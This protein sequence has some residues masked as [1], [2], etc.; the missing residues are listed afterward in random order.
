MTA[1]RLSPDG[2][3]LAAAVQTLGPEPT[4]YVTSIWRIATDPGGRPARLT[5]SAEGEGGP[6]FLPDG[7]VLFV[8]NRPGPA[9]SPGNV[10]APG[11]TDSG[12][13]KPAQD[14]PA[15]W[16]LPA[17][18][19]EARRVAAPP[20][21]V[22]SLAV[23][24]GIEASA[25]AVAQPTTA[26]AGQ[27][28]AAGEAAGPGL[29]AVVFA[30]PVLR[31][32]GGAEADRQR[33]KARKDA[34]VTAILH[35]SNPVR[36]WDHDLGPD[37]LRLQ[38]GAFAP[39]EERAD[40]GRAGD[41]AGSGSGDGWDA[42]E[43]EME[44]RELTPDAGRALDE[45]SFELTPDGTRVVTGWATWDAAGNR[46]GEVHVVD[47][48]TG[49]RRT[50]LAAPDYDF[51]APHVSPDGR[52]VVCRR[53]GHDTYEAPGDITLVLA[54]LDGEGSAPPRD[55]L[56]GLDRRPGEVAWAP[57]SGAVYF[58]ADD[59]GRRPVFRVEVASGQVARLT[60]DH[61]AY[62]NL[63]PAPDGRL[64]YA[65]RSA[66]DEPPTPVRLDV[67]GL[68]DAADRG[69]AR[70]AAP[71]L[72][73]RL[74]GRLEEI[75]TTAEDGAR[76]RAWLVLPEQASGAAPAPLLLWVHGGPVMSWNAWSWRWNP[77]LMA[78]RG[79]A[80]L[81]PDPALSTGYGQ[82]FIARGHGQ[83][84][85][86]PYDDLMAITDAAAARPDIDQE[87]TAM[88][89]GSYGGYMANWMAG[90]TDRFRAIVS[91]AGVWFLDQMFGTT[92]MP[93]YWRRMFGDPATQPER[94]LA[95]S[96]H[97]HVGQI[98]TP[99]LVIHGD[100]DYRVPVS[101]ALRLWWDLQ[102][103]L[104]GAKFLYFPDENHWILG[105]GHVQVWYETVLAFLAEHV[106]GQEWR[107]PEL[108]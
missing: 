71:G 51:E 60:A 24:R 103:R 22:S 47:V 13:G 1:L 35:E 37:S 17:A 74:P 43:A 70:L 32:S 102:G 64:L 33:R 53:A 49:E 54:A 58:T 96:P 56:P 95:S 86:A 27:A 20:G 73:V 104:P 5:R 88:M 69:V 25:T 75:E 72:P 48:A 39:L 84:G 30:S 28:A 85:G 46:I 108:L 82:D 15:L 76:I 66:V 100:K 55:L 4:K 21:G 89:G 65:L 3:W 80:V 9:V 91:H 42:D 61:G 7:S 94:Y 31:G 2:S 6:E 81:L 90:H 93:A 83:W 87:R 44:V 11:D 29:G 12:Q 10:G 68:T 63:C 16:L 78:A 59:H 101:E 26:T 92:D 8:S 99:M 52:T 41:G 79:Y 98:R 19:G 23:A 67:A 106:L 40:A 77:W 18:G 105:P 50:L 57:D 34:G 97:V 107:R 62:D 45:N 38:V 36:Y 14:K